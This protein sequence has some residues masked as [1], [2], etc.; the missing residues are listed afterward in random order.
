MNYSR[1]LL[2]FSFIKWF[3][4]HLHNLRT[5]KTSS[6]FRI[7][8]LLGFLFLFYFCYL[9]FCFSAFMRFVC[10]A[11]DWTLVDFCHC[12][13]IVRVQ[14]KWNP[15]NPNLQLCTWTFGDRQAYDVIWKWIALTVRIA[16]VG[17][18][19]EPVSLLEP[20]RESERDRNTSML[21]SRHTSN[22]TANVCL[23]YCTQSPGVC[24]WV[25]VCVQLFWQSR[26]SRGEDNEQA[27]AAAADGGGDS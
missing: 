5:Q 2:I 21:V 6:K 17:S 24:E 18:N 25:C 11:D 20:H 1:L 9:W 22:S 7:N 27:T 13:P 4:R 16:V 8:S 19:S 12:L 14:M 10:C 3:R 23:F 15:L 26:A